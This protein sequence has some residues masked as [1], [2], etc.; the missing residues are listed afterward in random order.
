MSG[1]FTLRNIRREDVER[2]HEKPIP[3]LKGI[4]WELDGKLVGI[5]G[6]AYYGQFIMAF[7]DIADAMR[8]HLKTIT[9]AR[10]IMACRKLF[11]ACIA[12]VFAQRNKDEP[13][14]A[15]MLERLGFV[16]LEENEEFYE[17]QN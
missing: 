8:P 14:S 1:D 3:S 10:G 13:T 5:A 12:P 4:A 9:T 17:W 11:N 2:F 7:S 6:I 15:A 16:Q